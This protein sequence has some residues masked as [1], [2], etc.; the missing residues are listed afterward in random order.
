[1]KHIYSVLCKKIIVPNNYIVGEQANENVL[2]Y[3][4]L[5]S[6]IPW[7]LYNSILTNRYSLCRMSLHCNQ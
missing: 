5:F 7:I 3:D 6:I 4:D 1:M 2:F